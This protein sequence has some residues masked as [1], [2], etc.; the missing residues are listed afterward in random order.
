VADYKKKQTDEMNKVKDDES[1]DEDYEDK[2][3]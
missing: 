1:K 3:R 2:I